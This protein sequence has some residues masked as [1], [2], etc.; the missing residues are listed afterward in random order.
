[1]LKRFWAMS[2]V[3]VMV[4]AI[5]LTACSK[6]DD[7]QTVGE[8]QQNTNNEDTKEEYQGE[9]VL[10][11]YLSSEPQTLDPQQMW[12]QPDIMVENMFMEGLMRFGKDDSSL[13]PGVAKGYTYDEAS[14]TY[15]FELREDAKWE[16]GTPITADDFFFAWRLAVDTAAP[17]SFLITDYIEG[18]ADYAAYDKASFLAEKD[19][20]FANL[21]EEEQAARI[22]AMADDELKQYNAKKD[23][24][25]SQVKAVAEGS[26]IKITLSIPAPYFPSLTAFAVYTPAREDFYK[27]KSAKNKY[28]I[29]AEGLLANGPW[30]VEE[31]VHKDYFKLVK[32]ENYWN[33]DNINIDVINLKIVNEVETRT[34]LLKTGAL[35][36][37]AI[38]SK[39]VPDFEDMATLEELN[40]QPMINR[41]DF[42]VF[43]IDFNHFDNPIIQNKNIR[44]ALMYAMDRTSFVE[45]I[46]IGDEP[47]LAFVPKVFPGLE[48]TFREENG[49]ELFK[50]NDKEK[51]KEY[52]EAGLK[53]LGLTELPPL[54][55]L[56]GDSD[57]DQKVGEKFQADW[58]EI[59]ITVNLVPLPWGERLTRLQKGDFA[60][61]SSGWGPDYPDAMTFL[62]LFES[63]NPNNNGQYNNPEYDKLIKAAKNEKDAKKRIQYLYDAEK[64]LME[65]AVIVPQY[66]RNVHFTFKK[67]VTGVVIRGV[68]ATTDFYW[69]DIDMAAKAAEKK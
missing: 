52:L 14:N 34:N 41:S 22:E 47:A 7:N 61:S 4:F 37:S 15:T 42:S 29:E 50:D 57:I 46:N 44:K 68:G 64:M 28:G 25:W 10:D 38:Q 67:Y 17:Y 36:G 53:E 27:E 24:L 30:K 51:A 5:A 63:V 60:M 59:G 45:K 9:K 3:L 54:D 23:E 49:M 16:D 56:I 21:S 40:L 33:K 18:A 26:N 19:A 39:D 69:A 12:G 66:F 11:Y 58:K 55:M 31:W 65:D 32:N 48:K 13:E 1:M 43:Y 2:L 62:E 35:D 8:A 20:A 6:S